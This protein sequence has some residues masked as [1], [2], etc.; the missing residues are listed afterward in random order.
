MNRNQRLVLEE[1]SSA[2][3]PLKAYELLEKLRDKGVNAP[4]TVYRAL[5]GLM[6]AGRVKKIAS[7]NAFLATA[8]AGAAFMICS[9]CGAAVECPVEPD[10]LHRIFGSS[11]MSIDSAFLEAHGSCGCEP[12]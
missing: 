9:D 5:D 4:M 3:R 8:S 6:A 11:G 7:L 2:A 1:L 12:P 10:V